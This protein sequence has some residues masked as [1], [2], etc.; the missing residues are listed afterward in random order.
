[1]VIPGFFRVFSGRQSESVYSIRLTRSSERRLF[2]GLS[3]FGNMHKGKSNFPDCGTSR[4]TRC[5]S[6]MDIVILAFV[7]G[8]LLTVAGYAHYRIRAHTRGIGARAL[9]HVMLVIVGFICGYVIATRIAPEGGA[10]EVFLL[11]SGFGLVHV[12]AAIMFFKQQRSERRS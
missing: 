10:A 6:D 12:P 7:A 1:M 11:L 9:L 4:R 2:D 5:R 3:S 8:V